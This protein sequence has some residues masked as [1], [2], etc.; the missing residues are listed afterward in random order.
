MLGQWDKGNLTI[1][2]GLLEPTS[3]FSYNTGTQTAVQG[4]IAWMNGWD[5]FNQVQYL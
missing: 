4:G 3:N 5:A 2:S 1:Q